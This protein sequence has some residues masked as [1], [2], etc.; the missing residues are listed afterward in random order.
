MNIAPNAP[1]AT[2]DPLTHI[3]RHIFILN[4]FPL[5]LRRNTVSLESF[6][7][8]LAAG[9][10]LLEVLHLS[11]TDFEQASQQE[12]LGNPGDIGDG[13]VAVD[14]K[15]D[16]LFFGLFDSLLVKHHDD[17]TARYF[18]FTT[19][20]DADFIIRLSSML[21]QKLGQGIYD[22]D[23][24][25][26]FT[27]IDKIK[28]L[29]RGKYITPR[30]AL[31]QTWMNDS[32]TVSIGYAISPMRQLR[33]MILERAKRQPDLAVRSKGTIAD[34][35][36]LNL[37]SV[38]AQVPLDKQLTIEEGV[39]KFT[40]LYYRLTQ[41]EL[42]VFDVLKVRIFGPDA[43]YSPQAD[44]SLFFSTSGVVSFTHMLPIIERL[45]KMYGPDLAGEGQLES[46]EIEAL[47]EGKYWGGRTWMLNEGHGMYDPNAEGQKTIYIV[48]A[49][50]DENN[51]GFTVDVTGYNK[52]LEYFAV[53]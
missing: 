32:Y 36:K 10:P 18:F 26:P 42:N 1:A 48:W 39:L 53:H 23:R 35:L 52:M 12:L 37:A 33:L 19:T 49:A 5:M 11:A 6:L 2:H 7:D 51:N 46:Y 20:Q 43:S 44:V 17:G 28:S 24:F 34:L 9:Q 45:I 3:L 30:D 21:F 27:E 22:S 25:T 50:L 47:Q 15:F 40:D 31:F 38:M 14:K 41:P 4:Y 13:V 29:S 16:T 8:A